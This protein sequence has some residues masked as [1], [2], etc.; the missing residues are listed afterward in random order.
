[1][2]VITSSRHRVYKL[3]STGCPGARF[4]TFVL[5]FGGLAGFGLA[6]FELVGF[7]LRVRG[8]AILHTSY[9]NTFSTV[10]RAIT[11]L[12]LLGDAW[13]PLLAHDG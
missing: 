12:P 2:I 6:G 11:V 4:S 8:S 7:G 13:H 5:G 1:M 3:L 10:R 9:R